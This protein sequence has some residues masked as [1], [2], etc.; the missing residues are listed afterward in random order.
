MYVMN[1]EKTH[2]AEIEDAIRFA[3][4]HLD[5]AKDLKKPVLTHSIRVGMDLM[6]RGYD[7]DIVIGGILHDILEDTDVDRAGIEAGFGTAVADIVERCTKNEDIEDKFERREDVVSRSA[8]ALDSAL[9]KS[10][11]ILDNYR[12]YK[13]LDDENGMEYC[14]SNAGFMKKHASSYE[15][16]PLLLEVFE[17][18]Q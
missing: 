15:P 18:A 13:A 4:K 8:Q 12:Y 7:T 5:G 3:A 9:V 16:D 6:S 10:A 1:D 14:Q 11:D 17:L 2:R